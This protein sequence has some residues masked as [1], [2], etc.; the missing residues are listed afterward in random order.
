MALKSQDTTQDTIVNLTRT[1]N[2]V[3]RLTFLCKKKK[4]IFCAFIVEKLKDRIHNFIREKHN[5]RQPCCAFSGNRKS[6]RNEVACHDLK[7]NY[8]IM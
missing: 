8:V 3:S 7:T 2:F 6:W 1:N 5:S 4:Y